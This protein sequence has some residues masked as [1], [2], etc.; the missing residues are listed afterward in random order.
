[1]VTGNETIDMKDKTVKEECTTAIASM[2]QHPKIEKRSLHL[3]R[4][5][6]QER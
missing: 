1:M 2:D 4:I 6:L 3:H 5:H